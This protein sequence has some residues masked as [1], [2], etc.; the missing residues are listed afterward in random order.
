MLRRALDTTMLPALSEIP[1]GQSKHTQ[2][3]Q[4]EFQKLI[5]YDDSCPNVVVICC[6]SDMVLHVDSDASHL[7]LPK[8]RNIIARHFQSSN[9]PKG[10]NH[11]FLNGALLVAC[12]VLHHVLLSAAESETAGVFLQLPTCYLNSMH[13]RSSQSCLARNSCQN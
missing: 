5:D 3:T 2:H 13:A 1:C 8:A 11:P 4:Q 10:N 9:H 7:V 6:A 12:T